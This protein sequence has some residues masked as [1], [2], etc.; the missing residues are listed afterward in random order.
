MWI[1]CL[2]LALGKKKNLNYSEQNVSFCH[3]HSAVFNLHVCTSVSL[4]YFLWKWF[5]K[6]IVCVL[7]GA[8]FSVLPLLC[9]SWAASHSSNLPEYKTL[10]FHSSSILFSLLFLFPY[11]RLS[12]IGGFFLFYFKFVKQI[13]CGSAAVAASAEP[14]FSL[15][16]SGNKRERF[17]KVG[18]G[19]LLLNKTVTQLNG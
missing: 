3:C 14:L 12:T 11:V 15:F 6:L 7:S 8:D 18:R 2:M 19:Q 17:Q 9:I 5:Q 1:Y 4:L 16:F 10:P 13:C